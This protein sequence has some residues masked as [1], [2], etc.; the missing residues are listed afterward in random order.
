MR[1]R[2]VKTTVII[3]FFTA[4][5]QEHE[6]HL[7]QEQDQRQIN[8]EFGMWKANEFKKKVLRYLLLSWAITMGDICGKLHHNDFTDESLISLGLATNEE[9]K[10]INKYG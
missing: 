1:S 5:K 2:N 6:Q 3:R 8:L 4:S 10:K 9:L 7:D